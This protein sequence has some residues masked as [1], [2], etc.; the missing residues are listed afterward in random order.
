MLEECYP[1]HT[2]PCRLP[3]LLPLLRFGGEEVPC[4]RRQILSRDCPG[5]VQGRCCF[6]ASDSIWAASLRTLLLGLLRRIYS[7]SYLRILV[8]AWR[9]SC[10]TRALI[11]STWDLHYSDGAVAADWKIHLPSERPGSL[12]DS[13]SQY[14]TLPV[15]VEGGTSHLRHR[16]H[17]YQ[18]F[19]ANHLL[20]LRDVRLFL[21]SVAAN[22]GRSHQTVRG[23]AHS[24]RS[25]NNLELLCLSQNCW[26]ISR[27]PPLKVPPA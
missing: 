13:P 17:L 26:Y 15:S 24:S 7:P 2:R 22:C 8:T 6:D 20:L 23:W 21:P 18:L 1:R 5:F 10:Q 4:P 3:R 9:S 25:D 14:P 12:E 16:R 11:S 27:L 19:S